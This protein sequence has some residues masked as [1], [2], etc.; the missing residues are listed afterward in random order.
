MP[1]DKNN[2]KNPSKGIWKS[3]KINVLANIVLIGG[4]LLAALYNAKESKYGVFLISTFACAGLALWLFVYQRDKKNQKKYLCM[5]GAIVFSIVAII[6]AGIYVFLGQMAAETVK[7]PLAKVWVKDS[8]ASSIITV[9]RTR[10][11]SMPEDTQCNILRMEADNTWAVERSLPIEKNDYI[12]FRSLQPGIYKA[13]LNFYGIRQDVVE[14]LSIGVQNGQ[15]VELV[16]KGFVGCL[17]LKVKKKDGGPLKDAHVVLYAHEDSPVRTSDTNSDGETIP[18]WVASVLYSGDY[19]RAKIY[20]PGK[21][22]LNVG[23]SEKIVIRFSGLG[24]IQTIPV[25]TNIE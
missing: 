19:Y 25:E 18:L 17:K 6:S 7:D 9:I 23:V 20:Y 15:Y 5:C 1:R 14:G 2:T 4:F 16:S 3:K 12:V 24:Q 22:G 13:E 21:T 8:F 11:W 10:L